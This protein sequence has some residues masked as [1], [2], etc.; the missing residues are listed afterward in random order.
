ME[1]LGI[2]VLKPCTVNVVVEAVPVAKVSV[3]VCGRRE[4]EDVPDPTISLVPIGKLIIGE[5]AT[6]VK[7]VAPVT[8]AVLLIVIVCTSVP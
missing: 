8:A 1:L 3:V 6:T 7:E 4:L 2:D 5:N